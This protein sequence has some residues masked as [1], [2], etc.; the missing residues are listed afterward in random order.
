MDEE[1]KAALE[2][3]PDLIIDIGDIGATRE[4]AAA[5]LTMAGTE[6]PDVEVSDAVAPGYARDPD[7]RVRLYRPDVA[8]TPVPVLLYMHG[9]GMVLGDVGISD[10][11][12]TEIAGA[13][14]CAVASVD[15]RLAPE[16]PHPAPV[17][18]CY[19]AL[20]WVA[21]Q[22]PKLGLDA[23]RLAVGGTSAGGGLAAA[24]TLLAR[25]RGEVAI[26]F[27]FLESPMLDDR[28]TTPSSHAVTHPKVWNRNANIAAWAALL[29]GESGRDVSPY[30]APARA[31]DLTGLPA[32]YVCVGELDL[33]LDESVEYCSRLWR[34]GVSTELHVYPG[35]FHGSNR[36]VP[37]APLSARW[38]SDVLAALSRGFASHTPRVKEVQQA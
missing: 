6:T 24:L 18:D 19:S 7:V 3:R 11:M 27:Q 26:G 34:A 9:G 32:T 30:A 22:G 21:A 23:E 8:S 33:F 17:N 2:C 25:D 13:V 15:Y 10:V 5:R 20:A 31:A 12:C 4:N 37:A 29:G 35:A 38:N 1:H 16:N 36:A 14:G 28:N